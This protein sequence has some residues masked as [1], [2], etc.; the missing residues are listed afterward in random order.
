[1]N[2]GTASRSFKIFQ[3]QA[4]VE[5]EIPMLSYRDPRSHEIDLP[6]P[7]QLLGVS[8]SEYRPKR[9]SLCGEAPPFCKIFSQEWH[10][11]LGSIY[12]CVVHFYLSLTAVSLL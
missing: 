4:A 11:N 10:D 2:M 8:W 6:V 5:K 3:F 1:M 12:F 7:I 9:Q